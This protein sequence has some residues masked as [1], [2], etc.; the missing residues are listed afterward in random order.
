MEFYV[1][2]RFVEE[3]IGFV[4]PFFVRIERHVIILAKNCVM[5]HR[6]IHR[7]Q[8]FVQFSTGDGPIFSWINKQTRQK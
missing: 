7:S 3:R 1:G 4:A 8:L 5:Y 2:S 6:T